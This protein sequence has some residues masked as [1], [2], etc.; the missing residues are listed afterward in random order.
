VAYHTPG[1]P[2]ATVEVMS[3][4]SEYPPGVLVTQLADARRDG[5]AFEAVWASA[6]A[7]ALA[8]APNGSERREWS[9]VLGEMVAIWRAA[10]ERR[11]AS[12]PE[13]ALATVAQDPD[14]VPLPERECEHCRGE[15][16]AERGRQA[17]FCSDKCRRDEHYAR[18][19]AAA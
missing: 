1:H 12:A 10:W 4:R 19:H 15:I 9:T 11:P 6:L 8:V 17:I 18:T 7:S 2:R 13:H 5:E 3:I 16:G 14:R